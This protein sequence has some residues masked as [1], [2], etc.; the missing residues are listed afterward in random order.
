MNTPSASPLKHLMPGWFASVMGWSGLALAWHRATPAFG[1]LAAGL[2]LVAAAVATLAFVALGLATLWRW[3]RHPE[4]LAADL[5]HPV[6][7]A[8]VAAIPISLILLATLVVAHFGPAAP[9]AAALWWVGCLAQFGVTLWVLARWLRGTPAAG[10]AAWNW[11]GITPAL[12]IPIVG[13]VLAPLAGLPLGFGAWSAAQFGVGLLFWP[14]VNVLVIVRIA[15]A[16]MLPDR[17]LPTVF[18]F[19]APPAVIGLAALQWGA[20]PVLAWMLWGMALFL[21]LWAASLAR[22]ITA[23]PFGLPH[24]GMSFPLAALAALTL[25][26]AQTPEGAWLAVPAIALLALASLVI[27]ALSLATLRGLRAGTL[28]V[29][30]APAVIPLQAKM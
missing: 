16:G 4:D 18:I 1:E 3:Q 5:K 19:V 8:F 14:L 11:Q 26:L 7:H 10:T 15:Q 30:E 13:N 24:W 29:P 12:F 9:G 23:Q 20:P 2:S 28:L 21:A 22:R 25:R 27:L 6:R 17:L